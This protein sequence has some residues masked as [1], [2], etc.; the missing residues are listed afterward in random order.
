MGCI[1]D[2]LILYKLCRA[3]GSSEQC[4]LSADASDREGM[5]SSYSDS[6]VSGETSHDVDKQERIERYVRMTIQNQ[7]ETR[8]AAQS[9]L[10]KVHPYVILAC[11]RIK[12]SGDANR[13]L[14]LISLQEY[15]LGHGP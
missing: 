5:P 8:L 14:C 13:Y 1:S 7:A 2:L 6:V 12:H 9:N 10:E 15:F 3:D 11:D 4:P